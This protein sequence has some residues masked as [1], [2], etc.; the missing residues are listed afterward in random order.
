MMSR[1]STVKSAKDRM[2]WFLSLMSLKQTETF[3]LLMK[4]FQITGDFSTSWCLQAS[5]AANT[6]V[7]S[8]TPQTKIRCQNPWRWPRHTFSCF[9]SSEASTSE[10]LDSLMGEAHKGEEDDCKDGEGANHL[11][12]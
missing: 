1:L 12:G 7:V 2:T 11:E 4:P 9:F 6:W 10:I 5:I 8:G 3:L